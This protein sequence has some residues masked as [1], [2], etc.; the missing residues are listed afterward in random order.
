MLNKEIVLKYMWKSKG[1]YTLQKSM[2][3]K[4]ESSDES[5]DEQEMSHRTENN[6]E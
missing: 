4:D 2:S 5:S 6:D 1:L 3:H